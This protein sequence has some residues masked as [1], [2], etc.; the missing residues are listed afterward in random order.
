MSLLF[1]SQQ[2][3]FVAI[4]A[5]GVLGFWRGWRRELVVLGF[6]L[7]GILFLMINGGQG[8][9]DF[10]FVK[11]PKILQEIFTSSNAK[12]PPA[13]SASTVLITTLLT[14]AAFVAAG[15]LIGNRAFPGKQL[16]PT[17]RFLGVIPGLVTGYFVMFYLTNNLFKALPV[18]VSWQT[19]SQSVI[20]QYVPWLFLFAIIAIVGGLIASRMKKSGGAPPSGGK[21]P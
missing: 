20:G 5:F 9:A 4:L 15:Y 14:F 2:C 21:K 6:A 7:A 3:F 19:P 12:E 16:T 17:E 1:T 18:S 11:T 10:F 8:V 13:P